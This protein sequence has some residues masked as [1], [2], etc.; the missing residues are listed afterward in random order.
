MKAQTMGLIRASPDCMVP[1]SS[2]GP[3][4]D[5]L[6]ILPLRHAIPYFWLYIYFPAQRMLETNKSGSEKGLMRGSRNQV[7]K[8]KC[9]LSEKL[10]CEK[11]A[12]AVS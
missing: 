10:S 12:N 2:G 3:T 9:S 5:G 6:N 11:Q 1:L 7:P 8:G 4:S